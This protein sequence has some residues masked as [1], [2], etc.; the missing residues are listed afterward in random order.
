MRKKIFCVTYYEVEMWPMLLFAVKFRQNMRICR[1]WIYKAKFH[2]FWI[3][4]GLEIRYFS[5]CSERRSGFQNV[6]QVATWSVTAFIKNSNHKQLSQALLKM[7]DYSHAGQ[8]PFKSLPAVDLISQNTTF[9][10]WMTRF[11]AM[12]YIEQVKLICW[13]LASFHWVSRSGEG[14]HFQMCHIDECSTKRTILL[15]RRISSFIY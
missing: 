4:W 3:R 15:S 6:S 1:K 9:L 10:D 14:L 13:K 7:P 12:Q 8:V 2:I 5:S 11:S